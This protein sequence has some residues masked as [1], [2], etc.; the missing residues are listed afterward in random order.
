MSRV[1]LRGH[2]RRRRF[3]RRGSDDGDTDA[4]ALGL[5]DLNGEDLLEIDRLTEKEARWIAAELFQG[6]AGHFA[7]I[8]D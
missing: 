3:R 8:R 6:F 2:A 1:E 7:R 4:C 5:V